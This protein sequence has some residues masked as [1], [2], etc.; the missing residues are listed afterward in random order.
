[1]DPFDASEAFEA[2]AARV[3]SLA[4]AGD[5]SDDQLL[6]LYAL[7]KQG[8]D[9]P[10]TSAKPSFF[11]LKGKAKWGAWSALG[12][13][14]PA[15][16]RRQYVELLSAAQ[17]G[18]DAGGPPPKASGVGGPVFSSLALAD[19]PPEVRTG[20]P[21]AQKAARAPPRPPPPTPCC[22]CLGL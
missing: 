9:G 4:G 5:L 8:T 18:W 1:M 10:C 15:E 19:D 12:A 21:F 11:D 2:A 17:P 6:K 16:A 14:P 13:L 7:F 3:A 22:A 20:R